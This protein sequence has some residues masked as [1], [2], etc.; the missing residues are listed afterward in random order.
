MLQKEPPALL[1]DVLSAKPRA[2]RHLCAQRWEIPVSAARMMVERMTSGGGAVRIARRIVDAGAPNLMP[3]LIEYGG[4]PVTRKEPLE[5]EASVIRDWHLLVETQKS[6]RLPLDLCVAMLEAAVYERFFLT[7]LLSRVSEDDLAVIRDDFKLGAAGSKAHQIWRLRE[8]ILA[9]LIVDESLEAAASAT[10][11]V[12]AVPATDISDVRYVGGS[13][14][15]IFELDIEG[16]T[17]AFSA[18][19]VAQSLGREFD[20]PDIVGVSPK[21]VDLDELDVPDWTPTSG[22]VTFVSINALQAALEEP[23]FT[24]MVTEQIGDRRVILSPD[25]SVQDAHLALTMLGYEPTLSD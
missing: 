3:L 25:Y 4:C 16:E 13:R 19:E 23:S 18:R 12:Q 1:F 14:G 24:T 21:P 9:D 5:A 7:T 11:E 6:W 22:V 17:T 15:C 8:R 10:E 20:Q 2:Q